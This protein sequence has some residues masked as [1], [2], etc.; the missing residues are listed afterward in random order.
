MPAVNCRSCGSPL[1]PDARFCSWCG[2]PAT[3]TCA[4]CG[5]SLPDGARFCPSSGTPTTADSVPA[6]GA[7]TSER[8]V[9]TLAAARAGM[10]A[11]D[12]V[13]Q[14]QRLYDACEFVEPPLGTL[15]ETRW[16]TPGMAG[17]VETAQARSS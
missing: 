8:K 6:G 7:T 10:N 1:S 9:A 15:P 14:T 5:T 11:D 13:A 17:P 4:S 12:L 2:A 16:L 3:A